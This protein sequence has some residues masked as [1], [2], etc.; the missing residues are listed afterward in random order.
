MVVLYYFVHPSCI[1]AWGLGQVG[2]LDVVNVVLLFLIISMDI[3]RKRILHSVIQIYYI[4][5]ELIQ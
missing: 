4:N 1:M 5:E 3:Q 2:E